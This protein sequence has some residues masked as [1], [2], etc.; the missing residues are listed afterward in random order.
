MKQT[1]A[2]G[3]YFLIAA[4]VTYFVKVVLFIMISGILFYAADMPPGDI[5]DTEKL[6]YSVGFPAFYAISLYL[7]YYLCTKIVKNY[8]IYLNLS[9]G[10]IFHIIIAIYLIWNTVPV[11]F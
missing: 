10:V 8:R 4:T 9:F 1:I 11:A 5:S 2:Y 3:I 6:W 7:L